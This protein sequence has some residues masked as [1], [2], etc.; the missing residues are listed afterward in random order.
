MSD[1]NKKQH[2]VGDVPMNLHTGGNARSMPKFEFL[3]GHS[4]KGLPGWPRV[5][6]RIHPAMSRKFQWRCSAWR[7][8]R[9]AMRARVRSFFGAFLSHQENGPSL[10]ELEPRSGPQASCISGWWSALQ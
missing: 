6:P 9:L 5:V 8:I 7:L 2:L 1:C 4:W 3:P 10:M